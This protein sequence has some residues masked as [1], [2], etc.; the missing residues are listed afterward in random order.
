MEKFNKKQKL[1]KK[2]TNFK[3]YKAGKR[4]VFAYS[5]LA[6]LAG[7]AG[8]AISESAPVHA[9]SNVEQ[10]IAAA[11]AL[12]NTST[13]TSSVAQQSAASSAQSRAPQS[14]VAQQSQANDAAI[15]ASVQVASQAQAAASSS[16]AA[17]NVQTQSTASQV[18]TATTPASASASSAVASSATASSV[19][20]ASGSVASDSGDF[21]K[22]LTMDQNG[23]KSVLM[24]ANN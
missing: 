19:T 10:S 5:I 9:D 7:G 11:A 3:M 16:A 22:S 14:A 1:V 6:F 8:V 21:P 2:N 17:T 12:S 15:Q 24:T 20:L 13:P 23:D 18:Q 4:W